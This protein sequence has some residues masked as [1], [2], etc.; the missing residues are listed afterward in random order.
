MRLVA[1][2]LDKKVM[3]QLHHPG[4]FYWTAL[5]RSKGRQ[6]FSLKGQ[7]VNV[8]DFVGHRITD[9]TTQLCY[10]NVKVAADNM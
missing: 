10:H 3:E 4:K 8:L 2:G 6:F 1:T 5:V 9:T 7:I